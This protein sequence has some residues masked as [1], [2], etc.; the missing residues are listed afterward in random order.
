MRILSSFPWRR[1]AALFC[2][3]LVC[4]ALWAE[5]AQGRLAEQVIRLHVLANSDSQADQALK[6]HVRDQLLEETQRL[7][8]PAQDAA[9]A[10]DL[11]RANLDGLTQTAQA[12]VAAWGHDYPVS[13]RLEETWF[14][15]RQYQGTALPA[16]DY[17]ALRVLIG[18][19]AGHNWWCVVF[20]SLCLPAVSETAQPA[21]A[22]TQENYA[23]ITEE[24][25]GYTFRFH[26]V[27]WWEGLKHW[28][29]EG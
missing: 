5:A 3:C 23:L 24:G 8:A 15:T 21:A 1:A 12:A 27:E 4:T 28:L 2:A 10:A 11:L 20:P 29:A 26:L 22:L 18:A 13:V 17:L 16:G 7:L 19:A 9:G 25:A 6:L 14:P